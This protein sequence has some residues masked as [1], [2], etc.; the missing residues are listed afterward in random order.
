M[1]AV[2][3]SELDRPGDAAIAAEAVPAPVTT[4]PRRRRPLTALWPMPVGF[5]LIVGMWYL[6]SARLEPSR[7][8]LLPW[9]HDVVTNG[10]LN[11]EAMGEILA[12]GWLTTKL[13]IFGLL[14]SIIMGGAVGVLMYRFKWYER[15]TFPYLVALQAVPILAISPLLQIAFGYGFFAKSVVCIIISFFPIPTNLLLGM[16]SV[17]RGMLD[18]FDLHGASWTTKLRKLALPNALP[19]LFAAFRISAGLSVIGAIVGE[20]FFQKGDPGLGQRLTQYRT[21]IEYE[22][23]YACLIMSSLLGIVVFVFFGW[24]SN[25]VLRSWHESAQH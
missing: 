16:K 24:L 14:V 17:D 21:L 8:F 15:M 19:S 12:S 13:A 4:V 1:T 25:R 18:L 10:F 11:G 9:P 20:Q 22:R 7:R 23:L 5:A 6:L 2:A 3:P